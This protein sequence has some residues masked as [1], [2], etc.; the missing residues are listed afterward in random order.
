M[1]KG[2]LTVLLSYLVLIFSLM[3]LMIAIN[4][5]AKFSKANFH[6]SFYGL[7]INE[8]LSITTTILSNN[9]KIIAAYSGSEEHLF[10]NIKPG[11]YKLDFEF[12]DN[13]EYTPDINRCDTEIDIKT[14]TR[15]I[16]VNNMEDRCYLEGDI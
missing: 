5:R 2:K 7:V 16:S 8:E 11:R 6:I 1:K 14:G 13:K 4:Q 12:T 10:E 15:R 9:G 3:A